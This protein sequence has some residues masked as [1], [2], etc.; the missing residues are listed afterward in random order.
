MAKEERVLCF[1]RQL[2]QEVGEF[3]GLSMEVDKYLPVV[4]ASKHLVYLN[5]SE[6][7]LDKR[8]KQLIPYVLLVCGGKI[9]RYRRGKGGQETRLHGLYSVGIGGHISEQ[10]SD[11]FSMK[12]L[13]YRDG[14]RREI[15]EEVAVEEVSES[16]VAVI[17]DDSTEVGQVHFGVVHVM[18]V[19]NEKVVG[20][21][22]GILG[23]EFV[24][25]PDAMKN[26]SGYESWSR[27]CLENLDSLLAKAGSEV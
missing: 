6:A 11:L 20:R 17:N 14:M 21:R 18:H 16:T 1:P 10:D 13:G 19:A 8:Y 23:P 12:D 4:T 26:A 22:S 24:H 3:Q 2:L 9:L 5:R 15:M 7:E 27:L 25:I